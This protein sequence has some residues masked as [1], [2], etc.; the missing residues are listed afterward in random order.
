[1]G[2]HFDRFLVR[3]ERTKTRSHEPE[4]WFRNWLTCPGCHHRYPL[5]HKVCRVALQ[6]AVALSENPTCSWCLLNGQLADLPRGITDCPKCGLKCQSLDEVEI[7][8]NDEF[9]CVEKVQ[10]KARSARK[11]R[12]V[13]SACGRFGF[14][15]VHHKDWNHANNRLG[16][17]VFR[18]AYCHMLEGK[19]GVPLFEEMLARVRQNEHELAAL[20]NSSAQWEEKNIGKSSAEGSQGRLM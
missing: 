4:L 14:V 9:N 7:A 8:P 10:L 5:H 1:M 18:C 6:I 19:L 2:K 15:D 11:R 17:R 3:S 13:C 20:Q 12:G 16:N